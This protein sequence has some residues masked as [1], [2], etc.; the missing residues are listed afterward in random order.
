[1]VVIYLLAAFLTCLA[2]YSNPLVRN[3]IYWYLFE[4]A[5]SHEMPFKSAFPFDTSCSPAY[6][7]TYI[8]FGAATYVTLFISVRRTNLLIEF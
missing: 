6:E 3:A 7:V 1:M 8:A 2:Y 5:P 4:A